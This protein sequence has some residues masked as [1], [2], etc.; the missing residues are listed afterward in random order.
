METEKGRTGKGDD[1]VEVVSC[2][3]GDWVCREVTGRGK[4]QKFT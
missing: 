3:L 1:G 4:V 2:L